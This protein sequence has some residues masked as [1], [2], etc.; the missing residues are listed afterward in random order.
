MHCHLTDCTRKA[1]N[2]AL[3]N[4][5]KMENDWLDVLALHKINY[6]KYIN[7]FAWENYFDL[8]CCNSIHLYKVRAC[9]CVRVCRFSA[10]FKSSAPLQKCVPL[11]IHKTSLNLWVRLVL[12]GFC[13]ECC[14]NGRMCQLYLLI[15]S[16][17][18]ISLLKFDVKF[19]VVVVHFIYLFIIST[20]NVQFLN[21]MT[22]AMCLL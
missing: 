5:G 12:A 15:F 8:L 21:A 2:N 1:L 22:F 11:L 7:F 6:A 20:T 13:G 10:Q 18:Y 3:V 16:K 19:D 9:V 17:R 14:A 4:C